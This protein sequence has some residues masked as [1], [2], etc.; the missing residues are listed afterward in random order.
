MSTREAGDSTTAKP[1]IMMVTAVM[2]M[3]TRVQ[4]VIT[5]EWFE[6]LDL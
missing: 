4:E 6:C 3:V 5:M 2:T 1:C